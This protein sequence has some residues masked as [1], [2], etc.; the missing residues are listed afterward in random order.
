MSKIEDI[1]TF[2]SEIEALLQTSEGTVTE[3]KDAYIVEVEN[4][5]TEEKDRVAQHIEKLSG[6]QLMSSTTDPTEALKILQRIKKD[7]DD[8]VSKLNRYR[9]YQEYLDVA[10]TDIKELQEFQKKFDVRF[11]LW[12]N[13]KNFREKS[14]IW[15]NKAFRE[16]EATEIVQQIKDFDRDNLLLRTQ[17]PRD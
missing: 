2:I 12:S 11:K 6:E 1:Q 5:I 13:L 15:F 10:P 8:S 14:N 3:N 9:Q 7:F 4:K 17:L 16:Q